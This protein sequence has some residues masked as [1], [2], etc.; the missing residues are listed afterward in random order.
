MWKSQIFEISV[1]ILK[2]LPKTMLKL[3]KYGKYKVNME[4]DVWKIKKIQWS[5]GKVGSGSSKFLELKSTTK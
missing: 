1:N 3:L 5:G 4:N 2:Q